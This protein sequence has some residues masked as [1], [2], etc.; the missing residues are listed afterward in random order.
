MRRHCQISR[1][2]QRFYRSGWLSAESYRIYLHFAA[3]FAKA[4]GHCVSLGAMCK[5]TECYEQNCRLRPGH[6]AAGQCPQPG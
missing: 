2:D 3:T 5:T 6:S 4:P 1:S